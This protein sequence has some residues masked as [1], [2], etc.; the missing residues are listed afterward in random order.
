M[1]SVFSMSRVRQG[2]ELIT[3]APVFMSGIRNY[4]AGTRV[5]VSAS[6]R[7]IDADGYVTGPW[8]WVAL[9]DG[10]ELGYPRTSLCKHVA[11]FWIVS[12][13]TKKKRPNA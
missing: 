2:Q 10:T 9:P 4:P 12:V 3:T 5:R 1:F 13:C 7:D 6:V 11:I 8:I